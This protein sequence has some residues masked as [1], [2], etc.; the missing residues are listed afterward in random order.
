MYSQTDRW[1]HQSIFVE[2][3]SIF[4]PCQEM[5]GIFRLPFP[6]GYQPDS[7]FDIAILRILNVSAPCLVQ[8]R[9]NSS[10]PQTEYFEEGVYYNL[11]LRYPEAVLDNPLA[12]D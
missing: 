8:V 1:E 3:S 6:C 11:L 2:E 4:R 9:A 10:A 7:C 5:E 12:I